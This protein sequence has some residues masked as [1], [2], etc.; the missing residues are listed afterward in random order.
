V[1]IEQGASPENQEE[2]AK[3]QE[4]MQQFQIAQEMLQ[5]DP[6]AALE[7][8]KRILA[9]LKKLNVPQAQEAAKQIEQIIPQIESQI[10]AHQAQGAM[11]G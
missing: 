4:L 6:V 2:M 10:E 3:F 9:E 1:A 7:L 5:Q 11:E 8:M